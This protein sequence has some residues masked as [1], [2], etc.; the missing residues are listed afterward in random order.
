[1]IQHFENNAVITNKEPDLRTS[2]QSGF[3]VD[4]SKAIDYNTTI[5]K[6]EGS[7]TIWLY[8]KSILIQ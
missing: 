5:E 7:V 1:M 2:T 3:F 6:Q 8:Q 4:Y